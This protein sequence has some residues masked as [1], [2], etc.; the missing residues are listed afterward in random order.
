MTII[1][2]RRKIGLVV[3][4]PFFVFML[5]CSNSRKLGTAETYSFAVLF[6][7]TGGFTNLNPVFIVKNSGEVLRKEN[8]SAEAVFLKKI[9]RHKIDSLYVF[10]KETNFG[11]LQIKKTSNLTSYIEIKSENINNRITWTIDSQL[12]EE[13][14]K[15]HR[16]LNSLV[17]KY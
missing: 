17:N 4:V 13:V 14:N 11:A 7:N 10:I 15:L 8:A 16:F 1:N 2:L 5:N 6:G 9:D 3:L 12:P